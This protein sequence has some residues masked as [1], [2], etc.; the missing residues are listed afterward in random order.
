VHDVA[1][2]EHEHA[3]VAQRRELPRERVVVR[4]GQARVHAELHDRHV[5]AGIHRDEHAPGAVVETALRVESDALGCDQRRDPCGERRFAGRGIAHVEER[6]REAVEIVD[7]RG[8]RG[9][10]DPRATRFPVRRDAQDRLRLWESLRHGGPAE[11][12][13]VLLDG[14][15]RVAVPDEKRGHPHGARLRPIRSHLLP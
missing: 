5:G 11:V 10:R 8:V 2:G 12:E 1:A 6:L 14:I 3:L 9:S 13:F 7:R 4:A 15:H